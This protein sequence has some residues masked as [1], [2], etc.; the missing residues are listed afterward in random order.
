MGPGL[1]GLEGEWGLDFW[2]PDELGAIDSW[3]LGGEGLGTRTPGFQRKVCQLLG[4]RC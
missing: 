1:L 2:N 4:Q 3:F